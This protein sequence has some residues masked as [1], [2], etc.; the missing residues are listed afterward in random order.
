MPIEAATYISDFS[1][2]LPGVSD[3][4]SEGDDHLRLIKLVCQSTF[5]R[6][7]K[8]WYF[9]MTKKTVG[10]YTVL[11]PS[12]QNTTQFIDAT[13]GAATVSLPNPV[14]VNADGWMV[15]VVKYDSSANPVTIDPG[16][17]TLNGL[18]A[19]YSFGFQWQTLTLVWSTAFNGWLL[20]DNTVPFATTSSHGRVQLATQ[21][22]AGTGTN[23]TDAVTP[24]AL[25]QPE[26]SVSSGGTVDL[27]VVTSENIQVTGNTGPITSFGPAA[28][29]IRRKLRFASNPKITYNAGSM[30]LPAGVDFQAAAGDELEAFSLGASNWVVRWI[31]LMSGKPL[32]GS[33]VPTTQRFLS[34][35]GT[36]TPTAGVTKWRVRMCG[37]GG[38]GGA[39][40]TN[41]GN[42]GNT[43]TFGAWTAAGGGA[44]GHSNPP[45]AG[46]VGGTGGS[47]GT[48]NLIAR[49]QGGQGGPGITGAG[50]NTGCPGGN[51]GVN[52]FGG[53]GGGGAGTTGTP[54]GLAGAPNTGAGGGGAGAFATSP[55]GSASGGGAGEYV[56]FWVNAPTA[57]TYAIGAAGTGGAAGTTAGGDGAAGIVIVE[58]YYN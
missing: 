17:N 34:G 52:P 23:N 5:P 20:L 36:C 2:T 12:D 57:T 45:V 48:G 51:G 43:T 42:P 33:S 56:E 26:Q 4:E 54:V 15:E 6:T 37:S 8:A 40:L 39:S 30:I 29:G 31:Q 9:P 44:G 46:G 32:A 25:Y 28:A 7:G 11:F 16:A 22:E 49:F 38:G 14:G 10:S 35:S 53:G 27:S 3:L 41:N 58:E 21:A 18:S 47:N 24:L 19:T 13:G 50:G 1:P 55:N